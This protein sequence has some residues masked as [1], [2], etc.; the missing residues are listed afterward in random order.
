MKWGA[1]WCLFYCWY[2][3]QGPGLLLLC[4]FCISCLISLPCPAPQGR[5]EKMTMMAEK[6]GRQ[7]QKRGISGPGGLSYLK[8]LCMILILIYIKILRPFA[9]KKKKKQTCPLPLTV[10]TIF[11][12]IV[13]CKYVFI[14]KISKL[15]VCPYSL[16]SYSGGAFLS[17]KGHACPRAHS[18]H[19]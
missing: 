12:K 9:F 15:T 11:V 13:L 17:P 6:E 18:L 7:Q 1:G 19:V 10:P 14:I 5:G 8:W 4:R 16:R 3:Y 2:P